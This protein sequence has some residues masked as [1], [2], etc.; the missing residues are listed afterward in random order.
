[1][2]KIMEKAEEKSSRY[3]EPAK[4]SLNVSVRQ[5]D[6][7]NGLFVASTFCEGI[8]I[9]PSTKLTAAVAVILTWMH[10]APDDKILGKF[11]ELRIALII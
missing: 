8:P 4:D 6:D 1:M 10:E 3:R 7:R 5:G 2:Q 9:L 11:S